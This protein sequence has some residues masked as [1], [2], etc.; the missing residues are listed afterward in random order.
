MVTIREYFQIA[1]KK[2]ASDIY[3]SVGSCPWLK[4][5]GELHPLNTHPALSEEEIDGLAREVVPPG[6]LPDY[7]AHRDTV[8]AC[9]IEGLGRLRITFSEGRNGLTMACRLIPLE[10]PDFETLGLPP[11][12]KRMVSEGSGLI[13]VIGRAGSG[14]TTT[15]ACLINTINQHFQ[16][17]IITVEQPVEFLHAN[18]RSFIEQT[19]PHETGIPFENLR[20]TG[21]LKAADVM[22]IDGLEP[23]ETL[24]PALS[25]A[26]EGLLVLATVASNGGV[27]EVLKRFLDAC[28]AAGR[29]NRRRLLARTLRGAI[30]QHLL[31]LKTGVGSIPAVEFLINDPVISRLIN[32][33]GSLHLIRPTMAAG[34]HKGMQTM[35][36]A[37][38]RIK[39]KSLVQ[40][41]VMDE[42][43]TAMLAHYVYPAKAGF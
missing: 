22:V 31:P 36:Q 26:T 11:V 8:S 37:L 27:A 18:K 21:F 35:F 40:E 9:T 43:Q 2:K 42:F 20:H 3:L 34:R 39:R 28:P 14:K 4:I 16:K 24:P 41:E 29:E 32:R 1:Q 23:E 19:R 13:L 17:S 5:H 15:L 30:W 7:K 38:E 6:K 10:V 33:E 12:L 25:A